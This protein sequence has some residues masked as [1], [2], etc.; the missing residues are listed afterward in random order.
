MP[1]FTGYGAYS[2]VAGALDGLG[3]F[4]RGRKEDQLREK[5]E[6][7]QAE[8]D[9]QTAL[10]QRIALALTRGQLASQGIRE[11]AMPTAGFAV[12]GLT[13][14]SL[15]QVQD[16]TR[17][18]NLGDGFYQDRN[19]TPAFQ[20]EQKDR[21]ASVT[22]ANQAEMR[23]RMIGEALQSAD[24]KAA[25]SQLIRSGMDPT[26]ATKV[27]ETMNP[28]EKAPVYGSDAWKAAK[29]WELE[30]GDQFDARRQSRG[31]AIAAQGKTDQGGMGLSGTAAQRAESL[32]A[33]QNAL[34]Q[35]RNMLAKTGTALFSGGDKDRAALDSQYGAVQMALKEAFNL[36]VLNGPDLEL[37][38][39]QL[40][41]PTGMMSQW[42][43]KDAMIA[44][45]DQTM[46][47]MASRQDAMRQVYGGG[48]PSAATAPSGP[49]AGGDTARTTSVRM[50]SPKQAQFRA[51]AKAEGYTDAEI[52]A[53][54]KQKRIP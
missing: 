32:I 45:I 37:L 50:D 2:G 7:R 22:A 13:E 18:T 25:L 8:L 33:V 5:Q 49:I 4:L 23:N 27:V 20:K 54:I 34:G 42:K 35:Y 16:P 47:G 1:A 43:G 41:R 44:Q 26:D 46:Q 3:Q 48:R 6:A 31:A 36:G 39:K 24:P 52:D 53:F 51:E 38:E 10:Q 11:G 19:L 15:T 12:P 9:K 21:M 14:G 40:T 17:Y 29:R 30:Q 28:A